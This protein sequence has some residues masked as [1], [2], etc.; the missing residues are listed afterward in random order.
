MM[1]IY[2]IIFPY[3][4]CEFARVFF[5]SFSFVEYASIQSNKIDCRIISAFHWSK[6]D[7][8]KWKYVFADRI[9][10][11]ELFRYQTHNSNEM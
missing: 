2:S 9:W 1:K 5:L 10:K 6:F 8:C 4:I 7:S 3:L 11:M